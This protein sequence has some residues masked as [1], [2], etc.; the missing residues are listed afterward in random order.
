MNAKVNKES[1]CPYPVNRTEFNSRKPHRNIGDSDMCE[2]LVKYEN[3]GLGPWPVEYFATCGDDSKKCVQWSRICS[4]LY[5]VT[6]SDT[7]FSFGLPT[8]AIKRIEERKAR[9]TLEEL[10][11]IKDKS[12]SGE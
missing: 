9:Q 6:R 8:W 2:W 5:C 4:P 12:K 10:A 1:P 7:N 3:S 11:G